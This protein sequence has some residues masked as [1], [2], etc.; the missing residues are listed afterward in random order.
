M[1]KRKLAIIGAGTF[2][3]PLILKANALGYETHVFAW[4]AGAVA[5]P[6]ADFFYDISITDLD[7]IADVCRRV[8]PAGILTCG[9]DLAVVT[10]NALAHRLGL[11]GNPIETTVPTTNKYQMR[12]QMQDHGVPTPPFFRVTQTEIETFQTDALPLPFIVKPTDRSGSRGVCKIETCDPDRL[13]EALTAAC[14]ASFEKTA[15]VEA[16]VEGDE[17]SCEVVSWQGEHT[18]LTI[19]RKSTTGAPRYIETGHMQPAGLSDTLTDRIGALASRTLDALGVRQGASHFEFRLT[20]GGEIV[21][22]EVGARGGG[23]FISSDLVMLSSG[24]DFL[25]M[26][27]D[28]AVGQSPDFTVHPHHRHAAVQFFVFEDQIRRYERM[29]QDHPD[30]I[31]REQLPPA[32]SVGAVTDS[33]SRYGYG[34]FAADDVALMHYI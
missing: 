10:V 25:K 8:A 33:S 17:F 32:G 3:Q 27:I 5:A 1:S 2:Q 24:Y 29:R 18:P 4:S 19:T 11:P 9:S 34:L 14:A 20:P 6:D 21:P 16:F 23:D 22:M 15:I 12:R 28:C 7:A 30:W 31:I 26:M 13:R